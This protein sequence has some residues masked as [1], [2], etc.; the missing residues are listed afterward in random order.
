MLECGYEIYYSAI[1]FMLVLTGIC[2]P[3]YRLYVEFDDI[4][5]SDSKGAPEEDCDAQ[6]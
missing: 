2:L 3:T 1:F 6:R 5:H 4:L